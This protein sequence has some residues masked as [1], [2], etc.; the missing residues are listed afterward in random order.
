MAWRDA[1][2]ILGVWR[3]L[4]CGRPSC[5][6]TPSPHPTPSLPPPPS[7]LPCTQLPSM[8]HAEVVTMITTFFLITYS[9]A[10]VVLSIIQGELSCPRWVGLQF[11]TSGA[12]GGCTGRAQG[13]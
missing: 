9:T 4:L 3:C 13:L 8:S 1:C 5:S 2:S 12:G 6:A 7:L 10:A 11:R